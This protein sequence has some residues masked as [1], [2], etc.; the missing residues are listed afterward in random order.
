MD[1]Q[2]SRS[3]KTLSASELETKF[4]VLVKKEKLILHDIL[5]YIREIDRRRLYLDRARASLFEYLTKDY[6]YSS[7]AAMRRINAARLIGEIPEISEHI[8]AGTINLTQLSEMSRGIRERE[9]L[10]PEPVSLE[11]K[12]EVYKNIQ[13]KNGLETQQI[14]AATLQIVPKK[15]ES[16]RQQAD[17]SILL[18]ISLT[19][20]QFHKL[21]ESRSKASHMLWQKNRTASWGDVIGFLS[22]YFLEQTLL[23]SS[24]FP[25]YKIKALLEKSNGCCQH[26]DK[27]KKVTCGSRY[28]LQIDHIQ[29]KWAGGSDD[30]SNLQLLCASHNR[31]KYEREAGITR[32]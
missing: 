23:K 22:E 29:P 20:P 12:K 13:N 24:S 28:N 31:H 14:V 6:G 16:L 10:I 7:S 25:K 11:L 8:Q 26:Y 4:R 30:I 19:K 1:S 17:E 9:A 15:K 18:H 27:E 3:L 32:R 21:N 2:S 5:I